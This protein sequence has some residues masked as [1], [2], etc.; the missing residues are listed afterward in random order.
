[1]IKTLV[2]G[3]GGYYGLITLGI[4]SELIQKQF[5]HLSQINSI[6][7]TSIGSLIGVLCCLDI[8]METI[9]TYFVNRPWENSVKI[10]SEALMN[11]YTKRGICNSSFFNVMLKNVFYSKNLEL[12]LTL[13]ELYDF[14]KKEL[15]IYTIELEDFKLVELSYKT[16]PDLTVIDAITMSCAIPYVFEPVYY[17]NKHYIDGGL[18]CNYPINKVKNENKDEIFGIQI[19]RTNITPI[20]NLNILEYAYFLHCQLCKNQREDIVDENNSIKHEITIDCE[21][22][23]TDDTFEVF[24]KKEVREKFVIMGVELVDIFLQ[25]HKI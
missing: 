12:T 18:L 4:L 24:Y 9:I 7:G 1:M 8:D 15:Y 23:T 14:S 25:K 3:G 2:L 10:S 21:T 13:K 11:F 22:M 20:T 5:L 17:N 19:K 6:Y 16:H